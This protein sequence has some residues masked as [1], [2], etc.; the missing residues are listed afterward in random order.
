MAKGALGIFSESLKGSKVI[1]KSRKENIEPNEE[2]S[3][4]QFVGVNGEQN[5]NNKNCKNHKNDS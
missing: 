1:D 2:K 5:A 3:E 4:K